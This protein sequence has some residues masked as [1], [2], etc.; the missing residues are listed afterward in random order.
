MENIEEMNEKLIAETVI[1]K[2]AIRDRLIKEIS[3]KKAKTNIPNAQFTYSD[4]NRK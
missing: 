1:N 4:I 3:I 2:G